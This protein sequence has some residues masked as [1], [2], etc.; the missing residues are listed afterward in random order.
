MCMDHRLDDSDVDYTAF[1]MN[2]LP[3]PALRCLRY[4]HDVE[5]H[6]ICYL[7]DL[8]VTRSHT[9]PELTKF[10]SIW[11]YQE[12]WHGEAISKILD[13]H[14]EIHG[15]ERINETETRKSISER[16]GP[17]PSMVGSAMFKSFPAVHMTWGAV[18]EWTTQ[19]AYAQLAKKAD[20]PELT[21]LLKAIMK[22][23]GKHIV[24]YSTK[25]KEMLE[26]SATGRKITRTLLEHKWSPVG[27][28]IM[29]RSELQHMVRYLFA[30]PDGEA[31][32]E[33]IDRNISRLPGLSELTLLGDAH[34]ELLGR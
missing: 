33:R 34:K 27:S 1:I 12:L 7:R 16:L 18:N 25:A 14:G 32:I 29:P 15:G 21:K 20:H 10:M 19:A 30:D 28:G 9:D 6:T 22:Q 5:F 8:L 11:A 17:I 4:M 23:E 31:S 3:E 26:E 2:P 24:F 13:A